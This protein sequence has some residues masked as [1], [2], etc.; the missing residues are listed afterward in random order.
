ARAIEYEAAGQHIAGISLPRPKLLAAGAGM[1]DDRAIAGPIIHLHRDGVGAD[2][3]IGRGVRIAGEWRLAGTGADRLRLSDLLVQVQG[4]IHGRGMVEEPARPDAAPA[5]GFE[6][7]PHPIVRGQLKRRLPAFR[8]SHFQLEP[9][10]D[11]VM[12][13]QP[14]LQT[15]DARW[16]LRSL[17]AV[18]RALLRERGLGAAKEEDERYHEHRRKL[19]WHRAT[20]TVTNPATSMMEPEETFRQALP[21]A[22]LR[23][24]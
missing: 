11:A 22:G 2:M 23:A 9:L 15:L 17:G 6:L 18:V 5:Q 19:A 1:K 7:P 10:A 8:L 12:I 16:R 3:G 21:T 20:L 13:D 24:F 14:P 4:I